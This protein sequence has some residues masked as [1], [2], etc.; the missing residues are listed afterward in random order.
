MH[1][2]ALP[3]MRWG[4]KNM[5]PN[6]GDNTSSSLVHTTSERPIMI[7]GRRV[8]LR[9]VIQASDP[10]LRD[11]LKTA[12]DFSVIATPNV[13][14]WSIAQGMRGDAPAIYMFWPVEDESQIHLGAS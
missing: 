8:I 9:D 5:Y 11:V 13:Q 7:D 2:S 1:P 12:T 10:K 3:R 14:A 6:S 4:L